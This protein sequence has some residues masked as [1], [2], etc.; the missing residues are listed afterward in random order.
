MYILNKINYGV[1]EF[2][3]SIPC[4]AP[5]VILFLY[6]F[7]KK[8]NS[9]IFLYMFFGLLLCGVVTGVLKNYIFYPIGKYIQSYG[10]DKDF[11]LIGR[12]SRPN[13]AKNSGCFYIDENNFSTSEGMPSGHSITAGFISMFIFNYLIDHYNIPKHSHTKLL[14]MCMCFTFY[15][16]YTRVLFKV[17]TIQQTIIGSF[18]G[19]IIGHYYYKFSVRKIKKIK[20]N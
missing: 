11:Y 18:I 14:L 13:N 17:H 20:K 7:T 2:F 16:M 10:F 8:E 5:F 19:I 6:L 1:N 15:M 3:R 12:F 4:I 9:Y